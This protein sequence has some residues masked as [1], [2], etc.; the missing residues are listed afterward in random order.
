MT[1][2]LDSS[3]RAI[4]TLLQRNARISNVDLAKQVHLSPPA[5]HAR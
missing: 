5:T 1:V 4:L 2:E 3:D